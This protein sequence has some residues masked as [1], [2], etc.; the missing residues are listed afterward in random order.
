[1]STPVLM[2]FDYAGLPADMGAEAKAAAARIK[3][4]M[5]G[6]IIDVGVPR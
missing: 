5:R 2:A 4:Y 6:A 3:E 1:M